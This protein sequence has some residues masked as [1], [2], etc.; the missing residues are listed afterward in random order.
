MPTRHAD[1]IWLAGGVLGAAALLALGW[2]F[3]IGPQYAEARSLDDRAVQAQ[4]RL[5]SQQRRLADLRQ[6]NED[7]P[8][9]KA[10]LGRLRQALPPSAATSDFLRE[11]QAAGEAASVS[12]TGLSIGA[13]KEVAGSG[14]TVYALPVA[15]TVEGTVAGLEGFV[16]ELQQVQPRAVLIGNTGLTANSRGTSLT[17]NLHIFV[18]SG[19]SGTAAAPTK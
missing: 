12:V 14:G 15:L 19:D 11:L 1:K 8:Q 6:Q 18:A 16:N 5:T 9:Y 2:F 17:V 10:Q 4:L 7:L 3:F 13:R